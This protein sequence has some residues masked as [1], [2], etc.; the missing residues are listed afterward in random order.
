[1]PLVVKKVS[2]YFPFFEV[3]VLGFCVIWNS[4]EVNDLVL[5]LSVHFPS[6]DGTVLSSVE[7]FDPNENR[8]FSIASLHEARWDFGCVAIDHYIY[9]I[10]GVGGQQYWLR[11]VER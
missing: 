8:W 5:L 6:G 7:R 4:Y 10:G 1:M 2:T 11:S 9:V 3:T